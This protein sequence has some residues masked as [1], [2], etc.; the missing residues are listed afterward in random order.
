M[1]TSSR[2]NAAEGSNQRSS[3]PPVVSRYLGIDSHFSERNGST[4]Q[5]YGIANERPAGRKLADEIARSCTELE[6][7]GYEVFSILPLVSGRATEA[8]MEAEQ[9]VYSRTYPKDG[10]HF[11]DTGVGYSVTDGVIITA[12]RRN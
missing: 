8:S 6:N 11:V 12:R 10:K 7:S 2:H 3:K 1:S 5:V 4:K 9:Q